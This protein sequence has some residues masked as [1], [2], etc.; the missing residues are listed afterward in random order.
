MINALGGGPQK[1]LLNFYEHNGYI[2]LSNIS[3]E[4]V[5]KVVVEYHF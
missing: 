1:I 2:N 5:T 4:K 3:L